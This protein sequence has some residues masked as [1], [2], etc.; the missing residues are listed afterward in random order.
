MD[1]NNPYH[2]PINLMFLNHITHI[3]MIYLLIYVF[4]CS[5]CVLIFTINLGE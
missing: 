3:V 1:F 2:Q 5:V 4:I